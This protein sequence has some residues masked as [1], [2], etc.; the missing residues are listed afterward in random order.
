MSIKESD[1]DVAR[2]VA[3]TRARHGNASTERLVEEAWTVAHEFNQ[4]LP[5]DR[6]TRNI[7]RNRI[8]L[9]EG[10][11][12]FRERLPRLN[13]VERVETIQAIDFMERY[14]RGEIYGDNN[15]V[16]FP[17]KQSDDPTA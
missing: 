8:R 12:F 3:I 11:E 9:E 5:D 14:L 6:R 1:K 4:A 15:V 17:P 7:I 2:A 10:V 13:G 16:S